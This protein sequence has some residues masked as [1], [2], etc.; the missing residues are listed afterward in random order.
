MKCIRHSSIT[1]EETSR[2]LLDKAQV[3]LLEASDTMPR[4][5]KTAY[6]VLNV[7]ACGC[8]GVLGTTLTA[9]IRFRHYAT[10]DTAHS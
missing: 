4:L 6:E 1:C 5:D 2:G 7:T 9:S 10:I 8:V 3:T